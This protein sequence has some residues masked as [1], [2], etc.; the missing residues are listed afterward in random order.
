MSDKIQSGTNQFMVVLENNE[1]SQQEKTESLLRLVHEMTSTGAIRPFAGLLND[2]NTKDQLIQNLSH[3]NQS[4]AELANELGKISRRLGKADLSQLLYNMA[5]KHYDKLNDD[6]G[7]LKVKLNLT[8][9]LLATGEFGKAKLEYEVLLNKES[10][11]EDLNSMILM[12]YAS[13][14]YHMGDLDNAKNYYNKALEKFIQIEA[15]PAQLANTYYNIAVIELNQKELKNAKLKFIK[16]VELYAKAG[17]LRGQIIVSEQLLKLSINSEDQQ[18][19]P[20]LTSNIT[21]LINWKSDYRTFC[22]IGNIIIDHL[23]F[24][25]QIELF[26][27]FTLEFIPTKDEPIEVYQLLSKIIRVYT[28]HNYQLPNLRLCVE[29]L[30]QISNELD[31]SDSNLSLRLQK[32]WILY[33]LDLTEEATEIANDIIKNK[34]HSS[35]LDFELSLYYFMINRFETSYKILKKH[36][37]T[38]IQKITPSRFRFDLLYLLSL[39][40]LNNEKDIKIWFDNILKLDKTIFNNPLLYL[41]CFL[42]RKNV[43]IGISF[44][45]PL[46]EEIM[47]K[48]NDS[49][50]LEEY[51]KVKCIN[52]YVK[53][54]KYPLQLKIVTQLDYCI[55]ILSFLLENTE[56]LLSY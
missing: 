28:N 37:R 44:L 42:M 23:D 47:S 27:E 2:N 11:F 43:S 6:Y 15:E 16:A 31:D 22:R 12:N 5:L 30:L 17:N 46:N 53:Y 9:L 50:S 21:K 45:G 52:S 25:K 56:N 19:L 26:E 36:T 39:D 20:E 1:L 35:Q 32:L 3:S 18:E 41:T 51:K 13:C 10:Q 40:A 24:E 49:L 7:K 8:N 33:R 34:I 4:A 55:E 54:V 48:F 14:W 38:K 29:A